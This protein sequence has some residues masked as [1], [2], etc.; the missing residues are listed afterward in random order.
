M[1]LR[2]LHPDADRG[3]CTAAPPRPAR[4]LQCPTLAAACRRTLRL[5]PND[6]LPW[7]AVYQQ[8]RRWVEVGCFES[9]VPDLCSIIRLAQGRPGQP[10]AIVLDGR[11]LQSSCESEPRAGYDGYKRWRGSKVH[12]AVDTLG[13][14]LAV[15]V[16]RADEQERARL[17]NAMRCS[18]CSI[19]FSG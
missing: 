19:N 11:T 10:S 18:S 5:L 15:H 13:H 17:N 16:T 1:E 12:R 9:M 3:S 6:F 7:K 4:S 2:W 8:S 14:L